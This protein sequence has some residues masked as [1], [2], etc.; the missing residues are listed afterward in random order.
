[1]GGEGGW[2]RPCCWWESIPAHRCADVALLLPLMPMWWW[3]RYLQHT[4]TY[5]PHY[6]AAEFSWLRGALST[7][8]R[9]FGWPIDQILH[10]ITDTHVVHHLF[11]TMPFYHAQVRSGGLAGVCRWLITVGSGMG[12]QTADHCW[13]CHECADG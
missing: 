4:A 12:V 3:C 10:H 6:R 1:V 13:R 7:V 9:T 5:I 11:H 8:D 2:A